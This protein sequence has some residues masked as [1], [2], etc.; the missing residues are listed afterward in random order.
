M[1]AVRAWLDRAALR[2]DRAPGIEEALL[3][4]RFVR[5]AAYRLR[6]F[7]ARTAVAA[8]LQAA[9]IF[10]AFRVFTAREFQ[11]IL[12]AEA[13]ALLA[14][15]F[16][17]GFL[18]P[19]REDVR[20]AF[21]AGKPHRAEERIGRS[22]GQAIRLGGLAAGI[23]ALFTLGRALL[24]HGFGPLDLFV[25]AIALR[26]AADLVLRCYHSGVFAVRRVY[27]PFWSLAGLEV[28]GFGAVLALWPLVGPWALPAASLVSAGVSVG[29]TSAYTARAYRHVGI[30]PRP[31]RRSAGRPFRRGTGGLEGWKAGASFALMRMDA[32]L[33]LALLAAGRKGLPAAAAFVLA[34][35]PLVRA[36]FDWTQ[37]F[38]FDLK[39]L[40]VSLLRRLRVSFERR[41]GIVAV[42]AA[43]AA[44]AGSLLL[45]LAFFR[46]LTPGLA[47]GSAVFFL[48]RSL[49]AALEMKAFASRSYGR[50]AAAGA[51]ILGGA[52]AAALLLPDEAA[53]AIAVI[54]GFL[55]AAAWL[56]IRSRA[57]NLRDGRRLKMPLPFPD[58]VEALRRVRGPVAIG[59]TEFAPGSLHRGL[60]APEHWREEDRWAHARIAESAAR[61]LGANGSLALPGP[62]RLIW[63]ASPP[64]AGLSS[65]WLLAEG[66]GLLDRLR[67]SEA[68]ANGSTAADWLAGRMAGKNGPSTGDA[69]SLAPAFAGMFPEGLVLGPRREPP[70]AWSLLAGE[71][72]RE[73]WRDALAYA[74][75]GRAHRS[76]RF[77]VTA[78]LEGGSIRLVFAAPADAGVAARRAWRR[79]IRRH[80][81]EAAFRASWTDPG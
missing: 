18:E 7:A 32:V 33:P 20:E 13:A 48:V 8:A 51:P 4:G 60:D 27:R 38:Y 43:G 74:A 1:D 54:A 36:G 57:G 41:L 37:L 49:A 3:G 70:A 62:G 61:R 17:W 45:G 63:F 69:S 56:A 79:R 22:L 78:S 81:R 42:A 47:V 2:A 55:A 10:V 19:M 46:R 59:R 16:W 26:L 12:A 58:W 6:F 34:A 15:S 73:I 68:F 52:V 35:S 14:A 30:D 24:G 44:W 76:S 5:Y 21:A 65:R 64:E 66:M 75:S 11:L 25:L 80:N 28:L 71:T 23:G 39:R 31:S 29:L 72:R 9:R 67:V 40:D 77:D 50:L 53:A